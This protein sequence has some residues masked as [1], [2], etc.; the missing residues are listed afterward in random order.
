MRNALWAVLALFLASPLDE[1][2]WFGGFASLQ[3]L[4]VWLRRGL[5]AITIATVALI[6]VKVVRRFRG[7]KT[8]TIMPNYVA[9]PWE[10]ITTEIAPVKETWQD[11]R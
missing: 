6:A 1:I 4:P 2:M 11:K 5:I 9:M 8:E 7:P 10:I 3:Y